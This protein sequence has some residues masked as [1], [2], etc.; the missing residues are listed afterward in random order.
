MN[1]N[2]FSFSAYLR[3]SFACVLCISFAFLSISF[4]LKRTARFLHWDI[5]EIE[6]EGKNWGWS[7][8]RGGG[9]GGGGGHSVRWPGF[10]NWNHAILWR[11]H[12]F[13]TVLLRS[14]WQ[15]FCQTD[16]YCVWLTFILSD[17]PLLCMTG[18]CFVQHFNRPLLCLTDLCFVWQ[19][20]GGFFLTDLCCV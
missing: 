13:T 4:S 20:F 14:V 17:R 10:G 9:R 16:L 5:S 2:S 7:G 1:V 8:R 19:I 6:V 11:N 3:F 12:T 15:N 18:L